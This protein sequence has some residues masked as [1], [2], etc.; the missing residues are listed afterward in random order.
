MNFE[1]DPEEDSSYFSV[2]VTKSNF[3]NAKE[4]NH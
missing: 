3:F 2:N 4:K 1:M